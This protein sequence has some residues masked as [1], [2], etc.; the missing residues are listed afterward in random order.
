MKAVLLAFDTSNDRIGAAL[1][2]GDRAWLADAPG[3]ALASSTLLPQLEAL[4][5]EA[6][7]GWSAIDA[8]GFGQGPGAF[9][10][11]RASCA[12]AQGLAFGLG[13]PVL[14]LDSLLVLAEDARVQCEAPALPFDVEVAVDARIDEVY[15]ARYRHDGSA[16]C[17]VRPPALYTLAAYRERVGAAPVLAGN[18]AAVFGERL[19][20]ASSTQVVAA[21]R[22]RAAALLALAHAAWDAGE[23]LDPAQA[24]P[25]YLRDKVALTSAERAAARE[26]RAGR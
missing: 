8:I 16:W 26:R 23:R 6:G 11:L 25:L 20:I 14:A 2:A 19:G 17:V 12:V 13:K 18:A 10:G 9:T 1:G 3:G 24:Q 4:L 7:L 15:A 21:E 5:H 22:S